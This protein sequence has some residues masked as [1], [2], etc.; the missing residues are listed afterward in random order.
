MKHLLIDT[1]EQ[2]YSF[3]AFIPG[4]VFCWSPKQQQIG[5]IKDALSLASGNWRLLHEVG[6]ATL[7]HD[8]Y[9]SDLELL[10][11]ETA[12]WEE[13]RRLANVYGHQIDEEHIQDCLDSYRDWLH[14]RSTCPK[15]GNRSLQQDPETYQ[16]FNCLQIWKVS[17]SRFCRPYRKLASTK[18]RP[19]VSGKAVFI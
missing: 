6:H 12:A 2:D 8:N 5:Y 4:D 3:L 16:C 1:L 14:Q 15:C 10:Q 13:A 19:S 17:S 7:G 11:L 9:Q 18:H